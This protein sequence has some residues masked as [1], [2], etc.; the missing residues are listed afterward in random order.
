MA[1]Q[2]DNFPI[3]DIACEGLDH[4][5]GSGVQSARNPGE[6]ES[7]NVDNNNDF[8]GAPESQ[9]MQG[10]IE[11]VH[12]VLQALL[13]ASS[14][15]DQTPCIAMDI[16]PGLMSQRHDESSVQDWTIPASSPPIPHYH[17]ACDHYQ[18]HQ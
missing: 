10:I 15:G 2:G 12:A 8:L 5:D 3:H 17:S 13:I 6:V 1:Q 4:E 9:A 16:D 11:I 18:I 14:H 7:L